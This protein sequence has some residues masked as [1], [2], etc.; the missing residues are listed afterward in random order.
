ML[1]NRRTWA[2]TLASLLLSPRFLP[3]CSRLPGT[4]LGGERRA[5]DTAPP[6]RIWRRRIEFASYLTGRTWAYIDGA[7]SC[8]TLSHQLVPQCA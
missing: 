5:A 7:S 3:V 1:H 4:A 2:A 6:S 8:M